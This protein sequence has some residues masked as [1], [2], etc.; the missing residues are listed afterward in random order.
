MLLDLG[1]GVGR[2]MSL[3]DIIF[4]LLV[5]RLG[6]RAHPLGFGMFNFVERSCGQVPFFLLSPFLSVSLF[7]SLFA[8]TPKR[9]RLS[10]S[11]Y[12]Y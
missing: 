5:R 7:Y 8:P 1:F 10:C 11:S 2:V 12:I 3:K 4:A 6:E 9:R